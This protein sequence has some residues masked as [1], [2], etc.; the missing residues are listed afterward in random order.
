MKVQINGRPCA[1]HQNPIA[2]Y[3]IYSAAVSS[4]QQALVEIELDG[5]K[6]APTVRPLSAGVRA[7]VSE[8][9]VTLTA[10]I[11]CKL[12]VEFSE[13][14]LLPLF[15]F[16][17]EPEVKPVGENVRYFAPGEYAMDEL[18]V[19]S[20][21]TVYLAEGAI[22]HAH[23]NV[24]D[25]ENVTICGRGIFDLEGDYSTKRR[26]MTHFYNSRGITV[27]DVTFTGSHGWCCAFWGCSNIL[28]D[29]VNVMTWMMCGDG[30]DIVGCH[31]VE[32]GGCFFRTADDCI[33]VKATD[34]RGEA[35]L[36]DVYN[37]TFHHC[38]CWNAQPGNGIEIGFETRCDE[39]RDVTF[40]DIDLIHCEHEGWQSGGAIT[41]HNGDRARIH[42]ITYRNI[43]VE[44]AVDKLFDFKVLR[45]NY[46][47]DEKRGCVEDVLLEN[48]SVVDGAFPPS[49]LSGYAPD[50]A[51]VQRVRFRN[52][53]VH[54]EAIRSIPQ[55]RMIAER[56]KQVEFEVT[57]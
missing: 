46:S 15:L 55:C 23:L 1:V 43:R 20:N 10:K 27:R 44:D 19:S 24:V 41:I 51:L 5:V 21:E 50:D 54:G 36:Q 40:S 48:I 14:E 47:R 57:E 2:R 9:K 12:S 28:M 7:T 49:I 29:S 42:Q 34:Y 22:V 32:V 4:E 30:V 6:T 3:V 37:V 35:G 56:T 33:A 25:A 31:D 39:I 38:V 8:G 18:V 45:S 17:Y 16:L 53:T 11:P 26:R 13:K 52:V